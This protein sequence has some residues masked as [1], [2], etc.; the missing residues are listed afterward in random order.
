MKSLLESL[1]WEGPSDVRFRAPL[2]RDPLLA[3]RLARVFQSLAGS[4]S[5]LKHESSILSVVARLITDHFVRGHGVRDTGCEHMAVLRV[6]EWLYAHAEQNVS[7]HSLAKVAGPSPYYLVKAFHKHVGLPPHKYQTTIRINR[8]RQ[9]LKSG[10]PISEVACQAGFF[11]QSHLNRWF[12][13]TLG[14]TPGQYAVGSA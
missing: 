3:W 1:E 14:M 2:V 5:L 4:N 9:L 8:A 10:A 11:D 12:K 7:I 13:K 6:R